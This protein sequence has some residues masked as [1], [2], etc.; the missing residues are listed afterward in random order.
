ML[1]PIEARWNEVVIDLSLKG[2][3]GCFVA[4]SLGFQDDVEMPR[5]EKLKFLL[6]PEV[7]SSTTLVEE[8][9]MVLLCAMIFVD[10]EF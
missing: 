1:N 2:G 10:E 5:Q 9:S 8:K 6:S 7:F 4:T 3:D